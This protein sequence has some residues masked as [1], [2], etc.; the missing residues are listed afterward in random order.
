MSL[1]PG[2]GVRGFIPTGF[3]EPVSTPIWSRPATGLYLAAILLIL[4]GSFHLG[5]WLYLGGPWEG[6]VSWRKPVLFGFSTGITLWSIG[7]L[8]NKLRPTRWDL[9]VSR[10]LA[11]SLILEVGLITT[12]Q[13][14]GQPSHFNHS[15]RFDSLV[16]YSMTALIV[17]ATL[18]LAHLTWRAFQYLNTG[19]DMRLAIRGGLTFLILSCLLGFWVSINGQIRLEMA[20]NPSLYGNAGV[21]KF[22]HGATLH[23]LQILPVICWLLR[24]LG[25]TSD[26]RV[27]LIGFSIAA[28]AGFLVYSMAQTL[29]GEP[30]FKPTFLGGAILAA[31]LGLSAPV[32]VSICRNGIYGRF[33]RSIDADRT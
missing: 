3:S 4:S 5:V 29:M 25:L 14:R 6:A 19:R 33:A 10:V 20:E 18:I 8:Y 2:Q 31:T 17:V 7:W 21:A 12:Q 11:T 32:V 15:S 1:R 23:G 28:L 13:W 22:P 26:Q 30:R 9:T 27:R 16:E 24:K